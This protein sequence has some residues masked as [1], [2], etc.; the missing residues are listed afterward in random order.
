M[1]RARA[2]RDAEHE[3]WRRLIRKGAF[4]G[5]DFTDAGEISRTI[6]PATPQLHLHAN[7]WGCCCRARPTATGA[8]DSCTACEEQSNEHTDSQSGRGAFNSPAQ[9]P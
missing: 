4:A 9:R 3:G 6:G 7:P 5:L 2:T 1:A 8:D